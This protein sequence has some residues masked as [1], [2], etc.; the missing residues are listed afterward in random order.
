MKLCALFICCTLT[1]AVSADTCN[2]KLKADCGSAMKQGTQPCLTC[3]KQHE[4]D[5]KAAGCT[6]AGVEAICKGTGPS[7]PGPSPGPHGDYDLKKVLLDNSDEK[8]AIGGR[9]L[10]GSPA[11][12]YYGPPSGTGGGKWSIFLQGG[13]ACYTEEACKKRA[14]M[15]NGLG[16][17]VCSLPKCLVTNM[18]D[19]NAQARRPFG[20][21][22]SSVGD[23]PRTIRRSTRTSTTD[24]ASMCHI[25]P[26]TCTLARER[27]LRP[28]RGAFSVLE[29]LD[30]FV[31]R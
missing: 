27:P 3:A 1:A 25:A 7:P 28:R 17:K 29:F 18:C 20:Q 10:D 21:M 14:K 8:K 26:A 13:G 9:C 22:V 15:K 5:L 19:R 6:V 2:A 4:S 31:S 30:L 16:K 24:T 23:S 12:Y 11:G